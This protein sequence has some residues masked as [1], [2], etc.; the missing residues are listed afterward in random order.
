MENVKTSLRNAKK[1][2]QREKTKRTH[3]LYALRKGLIHDIRVTP[4][5]TLPSK[6]VCTIGIDRPRQARRINK[7][8]T[9]LTS[10]TLKYSPYLTVTIYMICKM[11][12]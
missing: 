7:T 6:L 3:N 1:K 9:S 11:R 12:R 8:T 5:K 2:V 10:H 4:H